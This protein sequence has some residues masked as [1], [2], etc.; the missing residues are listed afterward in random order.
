MPT[1]KEAADLLASTFDPNEVLTLERALGRVL[2][3]GGLD[4]YAA[5]VE[6]ERIAPAVTRVLREQ[7]QTEL[8]FDL[9]DSEPVRL[10]GKARS[11]PQDSSRTTDLRERLLLVEPMLNALLQCAPMTFEKVCARLMV[12]QGASEA[13]A[14]AGG[15]EG[16][17]D[18]YGRLPLRLHD[19]EVPEHLIR[20]TF[21]RTD[22]LFLGQCK[23]YAAS[24]PV[25]RPDI[26]QFVS[27]VADCLIQY[28]HFSGRIP[29]H[30][31]PFGCYRK[32]ELA[33]LMFFTT[34]SFSAG[35][36]SA[37]DGHDILLIDGRQIAELMIF[38]GVGLVETAGGPSVSPHA[39]E[40]WAA[41]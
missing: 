5:A 31:V 30:H 23:R 32:K 11:R 22:L 21:L 10:I 28:E 14:I 1:A 38:N 27:Q 37:A 19:P 33:L 41:D 24:A 40:A 16:G 39:I 7:P 6:A 4:E 13:V 17:I 36:I 2:M 18:V 35:A 20:S 26:Q 3:G 34:S 25:G 29:S 9:S 8:M 15:D 12:I